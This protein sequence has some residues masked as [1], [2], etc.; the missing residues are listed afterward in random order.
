[1]KVGYSDYL[2]CLL[3]TVLQTISAS[4]TLSY[5][6]FTETPKK[7]VTLCLNHNYDTMLSTV[8][9]TYMLLL[10]QLLISCISG[11]LRTG[12]EKGPH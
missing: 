2:I 12:S 8:A 4:M 10:L 7:W 5:L 6:I 11:V 9:E 3:L 1:M